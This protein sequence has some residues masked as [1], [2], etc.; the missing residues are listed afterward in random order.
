[1]MTM[2]EKAKCIRAE[3]KSLG[4]KTKDVSVRK[5]HHSKI[6]ICIKSTAALYHF[7]AIKTIATK[8]ENI[9]YD[10][11]TGEILAGGNDYVSVT[12][13]SDSYEALDEY[14]DNVIIPEVAENG[15]ITIE[16]VRIT[17]IEDRELEIGS[18]EDSLLVTVVETGKTRVISPLALSRSLVYDGLLLETNGEQAKLARLNR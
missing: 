10:S 12:I 17:A 14:C 18:F 1:M 11:Y 4:L 13:D 8:Y 9:H 16:G 15:S 7:E 3:V 5:Q 2:T 6:D